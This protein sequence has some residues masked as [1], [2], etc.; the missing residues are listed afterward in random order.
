MKPIRKLKKVRLLSKEEQKLITGA[1]VSCT[2]GWPDGSS[3]YTYEPAGMA[4][5]YA[6]CDFWTSVGYR[7]TCSET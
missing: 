7:C 5:G 6:W 3:L 4:S 1:K 2:R